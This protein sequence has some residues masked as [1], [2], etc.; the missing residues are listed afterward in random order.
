[1]ATTT[2]A[3]GRGRFFGEGLD[4]RGERSVNPVQV[5]RVEADR[6]TGEW[7]TV[8]PRPW[9]VEHAEWAKRQNHEHAA[10]DFA[11]IDGRT[12]AVWIEWVD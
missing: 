6:V 1:M 7:L 12:V 5:Y 2:Y 8:E 11:E 4:G 10:F 3:P 9:I